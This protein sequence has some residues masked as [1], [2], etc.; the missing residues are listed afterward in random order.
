MWKVLSSFWVYRHDCRL[1][2]IYLWSHSNQSDDILWDSTMSFYSTT[3]E[4]F[5]RSHGQLLQK[6][7]NKRKTFSL[8]QV[9]NHSRDGSTPVFIL[10]GRKKMDFFLQIFGFDCCHLPLAWHQYSPS[11]PFPT[12]EIS[13]LPSSCRK[14][15]WS[16]IILLYQS[17]IFSQTNTVNV[18]Q[19]GEHRDSE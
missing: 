15:C 18:M 16:T 4:D 7:V 8:R 12:P 1:R 2:K 9:N 13:S 6:N 10:T 5:A 11:S 3:D 14:F 19:R 17:S